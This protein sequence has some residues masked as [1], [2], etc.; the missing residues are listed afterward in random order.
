MAARSVHWHLPDSIAQM[1]PTQLAAL[2]GGSAGAAAVTDG[3]SPSASFVQLSADQVALH[4]EP[5]DCWVIV[6]NEVYDVTE[7]L[8]VH[9]G[10]RAILAGVGGTDATTVFETLHDATILEEIAAPYRLGALDEVVPTPATHPSVDVAREDAGVDE[11]GTEAVGVLDPKE[12][13]PPH[14]PKAM[15]WLAARWEPAP[16]LPVSLRPLSATPGHSGG[17]GMHPLEPRLWLEHDD[18][19]HQRDPTQTRFNKDLAIK[20]RLL[21]RSDPSVHAETTSLLRLRCVI[22]L[23]QNDLICQARLWTL[24][25]SRRAKEGC[26]SAGRGES[27]LR[28]RVSGATGLRPGARGA[29]TGVCVKRPFLF[30]SSPSF[31][32]IHDDLYIHQDRLGTRVTETQEKGRCF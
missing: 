14:F 32:E 7:F 8:A 9:P 12:R 25:K 29:P 6:R 11:E 27:A 28:H 19:P 4:A 17:T 30:C 22:V 16:G 31:C 3:D 20:K 13:F 24:T 26:V 10:G 23:W 15:R 2:T 18:A 1:S 21:Q 5:D